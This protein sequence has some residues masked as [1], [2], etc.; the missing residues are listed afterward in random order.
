M[1]RL[2]LPW[3]AAAAASC[4]QPTGVVL[5]VHGVEKADALLLGVG[6][7]VAGASYRVARE[8]GI[9]QV[10]GPY[11]DGFEIYLN[12]EDL[13]GQRKLALVLDATLP[14]DGDGRAA[15]RASY[16]V[17]PS[18]D[19][20][21]EVRMAPTLAGR[22]QWVCQGASNAAGDG[23]VISDEAELDCDRDGWLAGDDPEDVDPL[24]LPDPPSGIRLVAG[25]ID[26]KCGLEA[27][28]NRIAE[29]FERA[30]T[31][32]LC[33]GPVEDC[34]AA[35]DVL[36]CSIG[37]AGRYELDAKDLLELASNARLTLVRL[38]GP[39]DGYF[40]PSASS[41]ENFPDASKGQWRVAFERRPAA[42]FRFVAYF[43]LTDHAAE[44]P[45]HQVIQ[46]QFE[47]N[48]TSKCEDRRSR[49]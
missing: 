29:V 21:I 41:L 30:G 3:L 1:V 6:E 38:A 25:R 48:E 27:G 46:V 15:F 9:I 12:R 17:A 4:S 42:P 7:N 28:R 13:L 18:R 31:C 37:V 47:P 14:Q 5:S 40:V 16:Q 32:V 43:L 2:V 26:G 22:G 36:K 44:P 34:A 8:T 39:A 24:A 49:S 33:S 20:L 23:F 45:S 35:N 11:P 10:S 19:E